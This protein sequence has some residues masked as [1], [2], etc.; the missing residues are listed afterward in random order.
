M[1]K[2]FYAL[3]LSLGLLGCNS[4]TGPLGERTRLY[5][6]DFGKCRE[7][8]YDRGKYSRGTDMGK[9]IYATAR[10]KD[11]TYSFSTNRSGTCS[12]HGGVDKWYP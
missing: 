10:C 4:P 11:G 3:A 12:W 9:I 2:C 5:C 6:D 1:S 7:V 8:V